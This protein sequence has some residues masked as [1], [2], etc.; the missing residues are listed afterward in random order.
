MVQ[1]ALSNFSCRS[2]RCICSNMA[3]CPPP[4]Q[5]H[6]L[7]TLTLPRSFTDMKP[8]YDDSLFYSIVTD[9]ASIPGGAPAACAINVAAA[10][11]AV[12][13]LGNS[14][15]GLALLTRSFDLCQP[16]STASDAAA[17][18]QWLSDPWPTL[19]M[20]DFPYPSS[21]LLNGLY[22]LPAWPVRAACRY[23][24]NSPRDCRSALNV[25]F[26]AAVR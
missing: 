18:S 24:C 19:A 12:Y 5:H 20:G 10:L 3:S 17:L 1:D 21:Y 11:R 13:D 23:S 26:I 4:L 8:A 22:E 25:R 7:A 9:D 2:H 6:T 15:Q 16:L 14:A